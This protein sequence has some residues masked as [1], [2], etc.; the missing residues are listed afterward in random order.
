MTQYNGLDKAII[1]IDEAPYKYV[2]ETIPGRTHL[3]H[4]VT[5]APFLM[6]SPSGALELPTRDDF[7]DLILSGRL[8]IKEAPS[9][10]A[11]RRQAAEAQWTISDCEE[12][13]PK[14]KKM[15]VQCR[16]LDDHGI[17]N[18]TKAVKEAIAQLWTDELRE[19]FGDHD[20]PHTVRRWRS[21]RGNVG[22]RTERQMVRMWGKVCRAPYLDDVVHEIVQKGALR[23]WTN[24]GTYK[25]TQAEVAVEIW[26]VNEGLS[27]QYSKPATPYPVPC[28]ATV[29]RACRLL[30]CAATTAARDGKQAI[31]AD[32]RGAGKP[33]TAGRA[34][35]L[36]IIDHTP[37]PGV[38]VVDPDREMAV[39]QPWLST[40]MDVSSR[41]ILAHL[42]TYHPPSIWTVG[43]LLKRSNLPK[44]PPRHLLARYPILRRIL[45]K[46]AEIILDN[47]PEFLSQ[48]L[49]DAAKSAGFAVR[50]CPIKM[51]RYRAMMERWY[52]TIETLCFQR[53]PGSIR[54]IKLARKLGHDPSK[55][56]CVTVNEL[57]AIVNAA[58]ARYHTEPHDGLQGR[59]PA[60]V[61]ETSVNRHGIDRIHDIAG[62]QREL[63]DTRSGVQLS[64]S[65]VR[66]F[67]LRYHCV[68]AVPALLDD[69]VPLEG[70]RQRRDAATATVRVKFDQSDISTIQVWNRVTRKYVTLRCTDESYA[71]GMPLWYHEHLRERA[72]AEAAAFNSEAE[73]CAFR[74]EIT[75]AI[76]NISPEAKQRERKIVSRLYEIPR[77]RQITGNLVHL[78]TEASEA[79]SIEDF[80]A[81]DLALTTAP[82]D[83]ILAPRPAPRAKATTRRDRRDAGQPKPSAS[84]ARRQPPAS[85]RRVAGGYE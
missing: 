43:E 17:K 1:E 10:I 34:L 5:G 13:D 19:R 54:P 32:W 81:H 12:L 53:L 24:R 47:A 48:A 8:A 62:F 29:R 15:L 46:S 80:I 67:N 71:N 74:A 4:G 55:E 84:P 77:L 65:G 69:L 49:E 82:D 57:E 61:F 36:S 78:H 58:I 25:E 64:K 27:E 31:E 79:V 2:G 16:L 7:D 30:E 59:Q 50:H 26:N 28:Y 38:F 22:D 44:R 35:E 20:N 18:G 11:A 72:R 52:R 75:A 3:M 37:I 66:L 41:A 39:S 45:G 70:K 6:P 40:H 63:M 60:L 14:A 23:H 21:E 68:R 33:L 76:R 85:T 51:P 42:I 9:L 56:A 73:R 83:E